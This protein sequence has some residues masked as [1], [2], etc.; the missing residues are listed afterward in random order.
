MP[1]PL[2]LPIRPRRL[3]LRPEFRAMLQRVTLRRSDFIVP[4]FVTEGSGVRREVPSMPGVFQ[5]SVD[6]AATWLSKRAEEGFKAYLVFGVIERAKKDPTGSAALEG[7]NVVCRLL[8]EV[9]RQQIPMAGITDLCFCEYTSH[10][11]CGP[12]TADGATVQNDATVERLV[13]QAVN[14]AQ[15]GAAVIAPSGMMDG[16]IGA[17][18][19]GLDAAG[20]A[21]VA[22]LAYAVKYASAFYGPFRDAADS[23]PAHG[24]R[25]SYQMDPARGVEEALLEARLD[26]EQGADMIMVKPAAAYLD[27]IAACRRAFDVPMVAYQVSGEYSMIEAAARN[28]WIDRDRLLL[29]SLTAIKRAGADLIISYYAEVLAKLLPA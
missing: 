3:R 1:D 15:A 5:M 22:L 20:F 18:R 10:G 6:V 8:R 9:G 24:D 12:L 29:E 2:D 21:D 16:T 28:G 27:V 19:R 4:V 25:K 14:H 11:H 13:T 23:A 7:D 26:V 17:L